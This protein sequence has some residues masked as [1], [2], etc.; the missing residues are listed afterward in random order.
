MNRAQV[1]EPVTVEDPH[2]RDGAT[3]THPAFGQIVASRVSGLTNLYGSDFQHH[4]YIEVRIQHSQLKRSLNRD[5]HYPRDEIIAVQLSEAQWASFVSS[6]NCGSGQC[7]TIKHINWEPIA[8]LPEP[9]SRT[10]QFETEMRAKL[11][12]T[13]EHVGALRNKIEN[14]GL[15]KG[16][17]QEI[18]S[19]LSGLMTELHSNLPFVAKQFGEHMEDVVEKAKSEIHGYMVGHIQRAGLEAITNGRLPLQIEHKEE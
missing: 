18:L 13:K 17:Q 9:K 6:L 11:Q 12:R 16:K 3:T 5:W 1:E 15:P 7:C 10:D 2:D 14:M 19:A 4:A 8:L